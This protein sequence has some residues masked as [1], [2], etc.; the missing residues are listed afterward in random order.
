MHQNHRD[1]GRGERL[2]QYV[3]ELFDLVDITPPATTEQAIDLKPVFDAH[4]HTPD[5]KG[6]V[7]SGPQTPNAKINYLGTCHGRWYPGMTNSI[8]KNG[9]LAPQIR[10]QAC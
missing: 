3:I 8:E 10:G 5:L 4:I 2:K 7:S 6:R 1:F 9:V